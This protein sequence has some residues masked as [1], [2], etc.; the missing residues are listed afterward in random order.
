MWKPT[1]IPRRRSPQFD[2]L[3]GR[4]LLSGAFFPAPQAEFVTIL[5]G[6]PAEQSGVSGHVDGATLDSSPG[7]V[8]AWQGPVASIGGRGGD[9]EAPVVTPVDQPPAVLSTLSEQAPVWAHGLMDIAG[10]NG[11]AAPQAGFADKGSTV[12]ASTAVWFPS[13]LPVGGWSF[14]PGG[15]PSSIYSATPSQNANDLGSP[16]GGQSGGYD[17]GETSFAAPPGGQGPTS[18]SMNDPP[19]PLAMEFALARGRQDPFETVGSFAGPLNATSGA[20]GPGAL[21]IAP[22]TANFGTVTAGVVS[23]RRPLRR[24][25]PSRLSSRW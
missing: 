9:L 14:T 6:P 23:A 19:A 24:R 21:A 7:Y 18:G 15:V 16:V 13:G 1:E 2:P 11:G 4:Q 12:V 3:E 17:P 5:A 25:F 22:L 20:N 8:P 10:S